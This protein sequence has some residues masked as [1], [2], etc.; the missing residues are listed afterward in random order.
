MGGTVVDAIRAFASQKKLF[1]VH[2]RNVTQPLPDGFVETF[3]DNGYMNMYTVMKAL[4]ETGFA[5]AVISDH[6]PG[7]AGGR[8]SAEAYS[9]GYIRALIQAVSS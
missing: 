4:Q 8:R 2:F 9:I 6:V 1:K 7:M 3:L 5:G